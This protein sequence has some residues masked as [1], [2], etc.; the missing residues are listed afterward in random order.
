M[1]RHCNFGRMQCESINIFLNLILAGFFFVPLAIADDVKHPFTLSDEDIM[2]LDVYQD[3][4]PKYDPNVPK[5][6][7][8]RDVPGPGVEFDIYF[9]SDNKSKTNYSLGYVSC[10]N[11]GKG[12]LVDIDVNDF[13]AFA[14]KFTL[15]SID[16]R[17]DPN[18]GGT[19]LVGALINSGYSHAF[20]PEYIS[21][22][23]EVEAVSV[24]KTDAEKTSI[25]GFEIYKSS[26]EG[27]SPKGNTVTVPQ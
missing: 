17:N 22:E 18:A 10:G 4:N 7:A 19:L 25:I 14:L 13:D 24:T 1:L 26:P 21:F 5:I 16:G 27:W 12:A 6:I 20:R 15:I 8:Q 3:S 9:P 23:K 11:R 2:S